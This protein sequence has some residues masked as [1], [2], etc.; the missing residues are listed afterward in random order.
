LEEVKL[1]NLDFV[2]SRTQKAVDNL[3][4]CLN[5]LLKVGGFFPSKQNNCN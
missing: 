3:K 5:I 4:L 1:I 2:I